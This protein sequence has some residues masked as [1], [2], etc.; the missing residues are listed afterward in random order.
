MR[1]GTNHRHP[2]GDPL[3][4]HTKSVLAVAAV[5]L[6]DGRTLLATGSDDRTVR[7]WDPATGTPVGDPLTGHTASV[8]AMGGAAARR[9]DPTATGSANGT[10]RLWDPTTGTPSGTR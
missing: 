8:E 9:A 10:V 6:P 3:T 1:C 4:G 2:V 5:L 7:L